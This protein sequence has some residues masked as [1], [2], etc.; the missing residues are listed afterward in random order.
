MSNRRASDDN[1]NDSVQEP[2]FAVSN[3]AAWGRFREGVAVVIGAPGTK[4]AARNE[5]VNA[6][7][8][9]GEGAK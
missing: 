1:Q 2:G 7:Q 9:E 4:V 8:A 6:K 3:P 5:V